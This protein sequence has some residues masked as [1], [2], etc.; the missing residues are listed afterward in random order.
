MDSRVLDGW[1]AWNDP[2][3]GTVYTMYTD[4]RNL[5]TVGVG[6]LIDPIG[7]ALD[8]AF[9]HKDGTL[10]TGDEISKEWYRVKGGNFSKSGWTAAA[11]GATIRLTATGVAALVRGKLLQ[12][13]AHLARRFPEWNAWPWQA[14]QAALSMS[15]AAGPGVV[16]PHWQAA[17]M[18][19]DWATAAVESHLDDSHNP[20]LRPRNAANKALYLDILKGLGGTQDPATDVPASETRPSDTLEGTAT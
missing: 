16:A 5:V 12:M 7:A 10:A 2:F 9:V 15:W 19:Q 3:E 11:K 8:L 18:A 17:C 14:Q 1:Q 20:G 6:N 4:V 13:E